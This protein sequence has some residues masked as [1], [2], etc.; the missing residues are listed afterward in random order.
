MCKHW[1]GQC[2]FPNTPQNGKCDW[3]D[4]D[5][6]ECPYYEEEKQENDS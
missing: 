3:P 4:L 1:H 2:I 6:E 5:I